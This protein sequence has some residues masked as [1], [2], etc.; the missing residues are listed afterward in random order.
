MTEG[1]IT[2]DTPD[3]QTDQ[4]RQ[5]ADLRHAILDGDE[6]WLRARLDEMHPADAS[7]LLEQLSADEFEAAMDWSCQC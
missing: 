6:P 5:L 2:P 7:D 3:E 4:T 1:R